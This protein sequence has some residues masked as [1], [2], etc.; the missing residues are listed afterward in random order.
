MN[1]EIRNILTW[2]LTITGNFVSWEIPSWV[3]NWVNTT[4]SLTNTPLNN[5]EALYINWIR[6][7]KSFDYSISSNIIT[8]VTSPI[9][10]DII[11]IDYNY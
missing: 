8:F 7:K 6:L 9:P 11:L 10:W 5:T 1:I 3:I 4:Y 2:S